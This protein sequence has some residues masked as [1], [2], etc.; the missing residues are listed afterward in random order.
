MIKRIKQ[1]LKERKQEAQQHATIMFNRS[2]SM[3][4]A[5]KRKMRYMEKREN[6]P[7]VFGLLS[8]TTYAE[9]NNLAPQHVRRMVLNR[10]VD[11]VRIGHAYLIFAI[12]FDQ[13]EKERIKEMLKNYCPEGHMRHRYGVD[14]NVLYSAD[15]LVKLNALNID[16]HLFF[17]IPE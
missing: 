15:G 3:N 11:C 6:I 14:K 8:T 7:T 10:I 9:L 12:N 16:G 5:Y 17:K 4:D 1:K 2:R 13:K